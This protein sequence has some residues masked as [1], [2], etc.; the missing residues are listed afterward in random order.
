MMQ[1]KKTI[2]IAVLWAAGK[3]AGSVAIT[4]GKLADL[5]PR[6]GKVSGKKDRRPFSAAPIYKN[7]ASL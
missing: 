5:A 4:A 6:K 3:P 2:R 7:K 1:K